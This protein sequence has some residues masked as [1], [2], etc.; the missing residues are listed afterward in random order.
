M[1]GTLLQGTI[2]ANYNFI[3]MDLEHQED[4]MMAMLDKEE[5]KPSMQLVKNSSTPV[6]RNTSS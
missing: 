1:N 4:A 2:W 6:C 5:E 3:A